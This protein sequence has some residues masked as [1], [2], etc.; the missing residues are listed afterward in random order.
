MKQ[1]NP[2]IIS[3]CFETSLFRLDV[4]IV[5]IGG[6]ALRFLINFRL[7]H[8]IISH[9]SR[10]AVVIIFT[11]VIESQTVENVCLTLL[12]SGYD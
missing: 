6:A 2:I 1:E 12:A 8:L 7:N 9:L 11:P 5:G 4:K 3:G 10:W